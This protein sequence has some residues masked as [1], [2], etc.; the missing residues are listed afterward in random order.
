MIDSWKPLCEK[1]HCGIPT[2]ALAWILAQG[3]FITILSGS[4][5]PDQ[6]RENIGAVQIELSQ[7]DA[8]WM[9]EQAEALD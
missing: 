8:K 5:T 7:E 3:D 2:L 6:V 1:Y 4:T 9:R